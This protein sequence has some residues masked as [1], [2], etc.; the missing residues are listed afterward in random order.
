MLKYAKIYKYMQKISN[1]YAKKCR[2]LQ[3]IQNTQKYV[4]KICKN[5]QKN[6]KYA[7]ICKN[8]KDMEIQ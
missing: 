2:K 8:M 4:K 1:L 5:M 6:A 7:I 3:N